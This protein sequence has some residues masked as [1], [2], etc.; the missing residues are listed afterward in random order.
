MLAEAEEERYI[1]VATRVE[2]V[3]AQIEGVAAQIEETVKHALVPIREPS[4]P[5][6]PQPGTP[7]PPKR[8]RFDELPPAVANLDDV[9][10]ENRRVLEQHRLAEVTLKAH[11]ANYTNQFP[12]SDHQK[13]VD[14]LR[15]EQRKMS[16]AQARIDVAQEARDFALVRARVQA[17]ATA[18]LRWTEP[19][20]PSDFKA[21][22]TKRPANRRGNR[23]GKK[24]QKLFPSSHSADEGSWRT[25]NPQSS[26]GTSVITTISAPSDLKL[27]RRTRWDAEA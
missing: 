2:E 5:V 18:A 11:C 3:A 14:E 26:A 17:L 22:R 8:S 24:G 13:L 25:A 10:L 20:P 4:P 9:I 6:D 21:P 12:S 1:E 7:A 27:S 23:G 15:E 19:A 16:E